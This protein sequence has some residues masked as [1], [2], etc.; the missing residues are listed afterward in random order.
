M[1][2][3]DD[4]G[5]SESAIVF[6]LGD[7]DEFVLKDWSADSDGEIGNRTNLALEEILPL[8]SFAL[9]ERDFSS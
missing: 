2:I 3:A 1:Q 8:E 4:Y 5:I 6:Q 7:D 9:T